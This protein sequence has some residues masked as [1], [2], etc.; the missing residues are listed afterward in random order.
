[1][2]GN[3]SGSIDTEALLRAWQAGDALGTYGVDTVN[4]VAWAVLDHNS[5][6]AVIAVPEP[7]G[8]A[9]LGAAL[10]AAAVA[11]RANRRQPA[12]A[13]SGSAAVGLRA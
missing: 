8:M 12:R 13:P 1:V 4:K 10:A 7:G 5:Q 3:Q 11:W 9:F 2:D 6:F